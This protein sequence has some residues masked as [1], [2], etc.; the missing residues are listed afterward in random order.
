MTDVLRGFATLTII[1][2][3]VFAAIALC[4]AFVLPPMQDRARQ[5]TAMLGGSL[6]FFVVFGIVILAAAWWMSK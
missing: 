5:T 3:S 1:M 4:A 6:L 2:F